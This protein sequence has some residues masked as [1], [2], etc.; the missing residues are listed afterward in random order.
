MPS[1]FSHRPFY[2]TTAAVTVLISIDHR[3]LTPLSGNSEGILPILDLRCFSHRPKEFYSLDT[4]SIPCTLARSDFSFAAVTIHCPLAFL[5]LWH[6]ESVQECKVCMG[7]IT[8][9][10][11]DTAALSAF[12]ALL[13]SKMRIMRIMQ[14]F[15][16]SS[17]QSSNNPVQ[18]YIYTPVLNQTKIRR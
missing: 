12:S 7:V 6:F 1:I 11:A 9:I 14:V 13:N 16:F 17:P 4:P 18:S 3:E 8:K 5:T 10:Y 2:I 15:F